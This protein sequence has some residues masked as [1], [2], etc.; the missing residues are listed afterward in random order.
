MLVIKCTMKNSG[1]SI[2]DNRLKFGC[3]EHCG[4]CGL[5]KVVSEKCVK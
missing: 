2:K 3:K 1:E 5:L 4:N